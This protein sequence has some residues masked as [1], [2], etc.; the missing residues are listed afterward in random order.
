MMLEI[1][2]E[3]TA[4]RV[5]APGSAQPRCSWGKGWEFPV[6]RGGMAGKCIDRIRVTIEDDQ[7]T[8]DLLEER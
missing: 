4:G 8:V 1:R 2:D 5:L 3:S 7:I 6:P